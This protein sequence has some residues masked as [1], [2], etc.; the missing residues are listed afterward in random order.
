MSP[1]VPGRNGLTPDERGNLIGELAAGLAG[2]LG[3]PEFIAADPSTLPRLLRP[4]QAGQRFY[5]DLFSNTGA[6]DFLVGNYASDVCGDYLDPDQQP[7]LDP[8]APPFTG[9]QCPGQSYTVA[10]TLSGQIFSPAANSIVPWTQSGV[11]NAIG[12]VTRSVTFEDAN[13]INPQNQVLRFFISGVQVLTRQSLAGSGDIDVFDVSPLPGQTDDC[14][15]PGGP[16]PTYGP[17]PNPRPNPG[18]NPVYDPGDGTPFIDID[19]GEPL[20]D[21]DGNINIPISVDGVD[22]NIGAPANGPT[23]VDTNPG[24]GI[25]EDNP[26]EPENPGP[27]GGGDGG[28]NPPDGIDFSGK[29]AAVVVSVTQVPQSIDREAGGPST[30]YGDSEKGS[31]GWFKWVLLGG[32]TEPRRLQNG[33]NTFLFGRGCCAEADGYQVKF[34]EGVSGFSVAYRCETPGTEEELVE[35]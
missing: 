26:A 25:D 8:G 30:T 18:P 5:C 19:I 21:V 7:V 28:D 9:G 12:P 22:I 24:P 1:N 35:L 33:V 2:G 20:V 32:Q 6:D 11:S 14:G 13:G 34:S 15:D 27:G 4:V 10:W 3:F 17:A 29:V 31:A 23:P 16:G